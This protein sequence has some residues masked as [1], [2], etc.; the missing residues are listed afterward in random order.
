MTGNGLERSG[1]CPPRGTDWSGVPYPALSPAEAAEHLSRDW[2][3]TLDGRLY[4][5]ARNLDG[6]LAAIDLAVRIL[7]TCSARAAVEVDDG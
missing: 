5:D 3:R 4:V 1:S 6:F 2:F 7:R